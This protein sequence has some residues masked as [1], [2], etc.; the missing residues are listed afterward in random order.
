MF[1]ALVVLLCIAVGILWNEL[2]KV[3]T[4]LDALEDASS[5]EPGAIA[6]PR[7]IDWP[8]PE[9]QPVRSLAEEPVTLQPTSPLESR[10]AKAQNAPP[11]ESMV[12]DS[13][14][15]RAA[16][17]PTTHSRS[18]SIDKPNGEPIPKSIPKSTP[19]STPMSVAK[20]VSKTPPTPSAGAFTAGHSFTALLKK[21]LF[22]VAGIGL[23]LLGFAFLFRSI[24]WSL[25]LPPAA[26]IGIA[27]VVAGVL[28]AAGIRLSPH[29]RIWG[30][31]AQ[32]GAA[33]IAYL[34]IYVACSVY[35]LLEPLVT[36]GLF[37]LVSAALVWRAL[38][39]ES[40]LL[41]GV[42]FLGAYAAPLLA[43]QHAG[44]L[45]F[46]LSYG[47]LVSTFALGVSLRK[48]WLEIGIH[49]HLCAAALAAL[50]YTGN[51]P[52]L[53]PATQQALLCA[54]LAV[55]LL[56]S[57]VW[58][59]RLGAKGFAGFQ[60]SQDEAAARSEVPVLIALFFVTIT[61]YLGIE[62]WLLD[63]ADFALVAGAVS[64]GL[65]AL[66]L[67]SFG[68][69]SKTCLKES[70]LVLAALSAAAGCQQ[71]DW[72][73]ELK[74]PLLWAEGA[75]LTLTTVP[76]TGV[77]AWLARALVLVGFVGTISVDD[78]WIALLALVVSFAMSLW[79][80]QVAAKD[81]WLHMV[82]CVFATWVLA[83]AL[84]QGVFGGRSDDGLPIDLAA[85]IA[86]FL[87]ALANQWSK[88]GASAIPKAYSLVALIGWTAVLLTPPGRDVLLQLALLIGPVLALL[89]WTLWVPGSASRRL[90]SVPLGITVQVF[91]LIPF[92]VALKQ[93]ASPT[94]LAALAGLGFVGF[95]WMVDLG[96][97]HRL[98]RLDATR[99]LGPT[100]GLTS[101]LGVL[102]AALALLI[103]EQK[104]AQALWLSG[105]ALPL[106]CHAWAR[107]SKTPEASV[108]GVCAATLALL[109]GY[110]W[111]ALH[112]G[113]SEHAWFLLTTSELLP[114]LTAALGV[115]FLF[116][117]SRLG[118]RR[119]WQAAAAICV[120]AMV[121][122]LFSLG[123]AFLSPLGIAGA[124]LCMGALF[125][126]A[127]YLAPLPPQRESG[128][129][130]GPA[131]VPPPA[132]LQ[133]P[134]Q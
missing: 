41:G 54:Y 49:A 47:L 7:A 59:R 111:I 80:S 119:A 129:K 69:L 14:L 68:L 112:F 29:N 30:Q 82:L 117:N 5:H 131:D 99:S 15:E 12:S 77:R 107:F 123:A 122:L 63:S 22:A 27:W 88:P 62:R 53:P 50:T 2:A 115:G 10:Q 26:R 94:T 84:E 45:G 130:E 44:G 78:Y 56:W 38:R 132:S 100:P 24:H 75:L 64:L 72:S 21:N 18:R 55:F 42:G 1:E 114:V 3:R 104:S 31:L 13:G 113:S 25:V 93:Q 17:T 134:L 126:L 98:W 4:R 124:L 85:A 32:G 91:F 39:E 36:L 37:A 6:R 35:G 58:T 128:G 81:G 133:V 23:L 97:I 79:G 110:F 11:E 43:L 87:A 120:A 40:K 65:V 125:L 19:K 8:M 57:I 61:C 92:L 103:P 73:W 46:N 66:A 70:A 106:A 101:T 90:T 71:T 96:L 48:A 108:R 89:A 16:A 34:S 121:K 83:A 33:A 109:G 74:G 67:P 127:G 9:F 102:A 51:F 28:G 20:S 105:A 118:E 116:W 52:P 60:A 86:L 95:A 76:R